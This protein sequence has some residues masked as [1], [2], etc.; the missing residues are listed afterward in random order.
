M[1]KQGIVALNENQRQA[2]LWEPQNLNK[3]YKVFLR[4]NWKE[5]SVMQKSDREFS[6]FTLSW[7]L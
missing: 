4:R 2:V 5:C 3:L 7:V 6:V 1:Q